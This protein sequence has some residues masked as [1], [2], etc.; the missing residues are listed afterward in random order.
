MRPLEQVGIQR[1]G[2]RQ[3]SIAPV[4]EW[5]QQYKPGIRALVEEL[6]KALRGESHRLPSLTEGVKLMNDIRLMFDLE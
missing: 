4:G 3:L 2:E 1:K 5:D 6:G